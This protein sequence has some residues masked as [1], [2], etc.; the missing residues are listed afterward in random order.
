M[1]DCCK[2]AQRWGLQAGG[3][4]LRA[5]LYPPVGALPVNTAS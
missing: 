1:K 5:D 3:G 4:A 2:T